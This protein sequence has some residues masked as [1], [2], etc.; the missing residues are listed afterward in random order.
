ME[1]QKKSLKPLTD[2]N[3]K[4]LPKTIQGPIRIFIVKENHV[5][6]AVSDILCYRQKRLLLSLI[7]YEFNSIIP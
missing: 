1:G 6:S 4:Y 7:G 3:K 2:F 5:G